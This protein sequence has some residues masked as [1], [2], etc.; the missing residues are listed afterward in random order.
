MKGN[1]NADKAAKS[2]LSLQ[3]SNIKPPYTDFK[4]AINTNTF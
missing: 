1:E 2:A 3:P 4:H